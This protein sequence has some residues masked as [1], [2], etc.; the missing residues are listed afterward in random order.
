MTPDEIRSTYLE[1]ADVLATSGLGWV[2][3]Q[4]AQA[5]RAGLAVEKPTK[6]FKDEEIDEASP[7]FADERFGARRAG[8]PTALMT[9]EAWSDA[10]R[11]LFLIDGVRQAVVRAAEIENEQLRLLRSVSAVDAVS[12]ETE[13][14]SPDRAK[15][16]LAG[17]QDTSIQKLASLLDD[18]EREVRS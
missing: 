9:L 13:V 3:E 6:I 15:L 8:K 5:V 7:L 1:L 16:H 4:V 10:D 12:F 17:I 2:V 14:E 18:L 11:L